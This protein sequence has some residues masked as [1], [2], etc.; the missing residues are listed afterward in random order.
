MQIVCCKGYLPVEAN[1]KSG[2]QYSSKVLE[3]KVWK[4]QARKGGEKSTLMSGNA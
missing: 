1:G 3:D 4:K 2:R